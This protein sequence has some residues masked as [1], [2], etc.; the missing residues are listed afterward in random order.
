[1]MVTCG[2]DPDVADAVIADGGD[3]ARSSIPGGTGTRSSIDDDTSTECDA[4]VKTEGIKRPSKK[5]KQSGKRKAVE[6]LTT[7]VAEAATSAFDSFNENTKKEGVGSVGDQMEGIVN[8]INRV[9][10]E[11]R[12]GPDTLYLP[13]AAPIGQLFFEVSFPTNVKLP[14]QAFQ[15]LF[16]D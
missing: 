7:Q 2:G 3:G 8:G 11:L 12:S 16:F 15:P 1:M 14:K 10:Q 9:E 5:A 13:S 6:D 4:G